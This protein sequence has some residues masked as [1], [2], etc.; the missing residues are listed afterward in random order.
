MQAKEVT[1]RLAA[2]DGAWE[3]GGRD[4]KRGIMPENVQLTADAWGSATAQFE[5]R[6]DPRAVWPDL[7]AFTPVEI[8]IGGVVVWSGRIAETPQRDTAD[9]VISVQC[10]GWQ[11]HLDDDLYERVYVHTRLSEW[12]DARSFLTS[13]LSKF[14]T[15]GTV[16][17]DRGVLT[18]GFPNGS[19][20]ASGERV[21]VI[22]DLGPN[23]VGQR[24]VATWESSNS[25]GSLTCYGQAGASEN[26]AGGAYVAG[27]SFVNNSAASGTSAGTFETDHRYV[28][29]WLQATTGFTLAADAW[30]KIKTVQV[31]GDAAYELSNAS[32]LKAHTV[33]LDALDRA[34]LLLSA[35]TTKVEQT[36]FSI[37]DLAV[38]EPK[39]PRE[40]WAAV[41]AYHDW[42]AKIDVTKR[43]VFTSKPTAPMFEVGAWSALELEDQSANSGEEIYNRVIVT[44][45]KP[46]GSP[47]RVTVTDPDAF[48]ESLDPAFPYP[49]QAI[50][51]SGPT[52]TAT[53][54]ATAGG[55][56]LAG[57][58]YRLRFLPYDFGIPDG[59]TTLSRTMRFGTATDFATVKDQGLDAGVI[60]WTPATT[61]PSE[62][63]SARYTVVRSGGTRAAKF[64]VNKPLL[65][66]W[67]TLPDRRGFWRTKVLPVSAALTTAAAQQIGDLWLA[68]HRTTPYKGS[69]KLTGDQALRDPA[70]GETIPLERL[71]LHTG[72]LVRDM[73]AVD[74]DTGG[75]GRDGRIAS[76][77]YT[78]ASEEAT[79]A[80]D[81]S[82]ASFEALLARWD[83]LS[84][85]GR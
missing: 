43:P 52:S 21:G 83:L 30:V 31:F 75:V 54:D 20:L 66:R 64:D 41:N 53:L 56:F 55:Q 35:D 6:R 1:V 13:D 36:A 37:P 74:P 68:A 23:C 46:D 44:G 25:T 77:T 50:G 65:V 29:I 32:L 7:G 5:L 18:L 4:R 72:E 12:R 57:T 38:S 85:S 33:V 34:T 58:M 49:T 11:Y 63:V 76:V 8:E 73:A 61:V 17:N 69:F 42:R 3:V 51:N 2:L 15:K 82:R 19:V 70:T 26:P 28:A 84:G 47:L 40:V 67:A 48:R 60:D 9:R 16:S 78:P 10:K 79:V 22:L 62:L 59:F 81:N 14:T 45:T 39:T 71:L 24:I 80:L 27:F